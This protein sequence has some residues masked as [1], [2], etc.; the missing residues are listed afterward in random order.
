MFLVLEK[1][2]QVWSCSKSWYILN[3]QLSVPKK[4]SSFRLHDFRR[5]WESFQIRNFV[6]SCMSRHDQKLYSIFQNRALWGTKA[7]YSKGSKVERSVYQDGF[8]TNSNHQ[9]FQDPRRSKIWKHFHPHFFI[10]FC[11]GIYSLFRSNNKIHDDKKRL[12][13]VYPFHAHADIK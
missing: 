9:F 6:A 5:I 13:Q 8:I 10:F 12:K 2:W 1:V 3:Y 4:N 7:F 11:T